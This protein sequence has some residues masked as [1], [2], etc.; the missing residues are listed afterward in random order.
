MTLNTQSV[1][2]I[3]RQVLA[4][5]GI[6]FSVLT[7][8]VTALHLNPAESAIL[9]V[10]GTLIL[11]IEHYVSDP[12]TGTSASTTKTTATSTGVTTTVQ[13]GPTPPA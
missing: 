5:V 12:S 6:V 1:T 7:Q 8:S 2:S 13:P 10:G 3:A 4:L 11:A 9:G